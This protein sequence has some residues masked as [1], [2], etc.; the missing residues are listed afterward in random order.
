MILT[1]KRQSRPV[2]LNKADIS[3]TCAMRHST[4]LNEINLCEKKMIQIKQ[5]C[6]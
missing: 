6:L 2:I 1:L 5:S 4:E 3:S